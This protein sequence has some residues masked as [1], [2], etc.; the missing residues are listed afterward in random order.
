[1]RLIEETFDLKKSVFSPVPT[2]LEYA[3]ASGKEMLNL[4]YSAAGL[5]PVPLV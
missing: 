2:T 4:L 3:I 5:I 1:M